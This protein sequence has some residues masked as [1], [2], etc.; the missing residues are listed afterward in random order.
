MLQHLQVSTSLGRKAN[1][2]SAKADS[3]SVPNSSAFPLIPNPK[4]I[5]D[6]ELYMLRAPSSAV[7][8]PE[9]RLV[10]PL[11]ATS[12]SQQIMVLN[13]VTV[14]KNPTKQK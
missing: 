14:K 4:L 5:S 13:T 12:S 8:N 1:K 7:Y 6:Q 11:S 9:T 10:T 2:F 3:A